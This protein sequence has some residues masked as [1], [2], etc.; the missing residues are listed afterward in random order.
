MEHRTI[1]D[2]YTKLA[3][4][5]IETAPELEYIRDSNVSLV[6]L[7]SDHEKK[8]KGRITHGECEKVPGK[9]RWGIPFD[10]TITVYEPNVERFSDD[11]MRILLLHELLHVGVDQD[12]GEETYYVVPHDLEDFRSIVN[13]FGADWSLTDDQT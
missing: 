9:Y 5:L 1:N 3:N 4:E 10:F 11:Q 2:E 13:R 6:V 8:S 12:G 7:S